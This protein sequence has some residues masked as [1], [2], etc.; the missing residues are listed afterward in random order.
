[1]VLRLILS[2]AFS[3]LL[4]PVSPA[5]TT[6]PPPAP[7]P[8]LPVAHDFDF[9][10]GDWEVFQTGTEIKI[11]ESTVEAVA[12]G[13]ALYEN[14]T[15]IRA[16][17]TG[18]SLTSRHQFTGE[19][20]Q[21]YV[22]SGG[23]TTHYRGKFEAGKLVLIAEVITPQGQKALNR[24]IWTNNPDGTVRQQFEQSTDGGATWKLNFDGTYRR[25]ISR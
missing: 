15:S 11:G 4:A 7:P 10:I 8:P 16:T 23:W 21:F 13:H 12:G 3:G 6:N 25:K 2:L 18:K 5:Q 24:G 17:Q 1:M 9:W 22:G 19:W 20:Q 14:W